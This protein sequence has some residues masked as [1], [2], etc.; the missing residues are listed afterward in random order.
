MRIGTLLITDNWHD[1]SIQTLLS[2]VRHLEAEGFDNVW[3]A[4]LQD[5]DALTA[6]ALAGPST[7]R[8]GLGSAVT[9]IQVRHPVAMAQQA[10]TTAIACNNRF[11]LGIGLSH[12][13][14]IE[15]MLGL[16]FAQP[17]AHMD[18]Y[19]DVLMPLLH[20]EAVNHK[21]PRYRVEVR[22]KL[23]PGRPLPCIVGALGPRMLRV[24]GSKAD[25]TVT[26][27]TGPRTLACHIVPT[28]TRAAAAAG[29]PAPRVVAG[30]PVSLCQDIAAARTRLNASLKL[31]GVLPSYR[32]MLDREGAAG[33]GDIALL[34]DE[35][36]LQRQIMAL[37]EMGVTDLNAAVL[38]VEPGSQRRTI[39]FLAKLRAW[40]DA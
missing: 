26:W 1:K 32:A 23:D 2:Y 39:A 11:T 5:L 35:E 15:D 37:R 21:G 7:S 27:M 12:K 22:L 29:R 36:A 31:Y 6:L 8:I 18:E 38:E 9:P 40:I 33:P 17:A 24:A 4:T 16:S 13:V 14:V 34:G 10:L 30:L 3:M 28:I 25:G 20:G 19:L